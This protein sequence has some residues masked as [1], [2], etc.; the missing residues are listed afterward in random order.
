M[1]DLPWLVGAALAGIGTFA[2][3]AGEPSHAWALL[4]GSLLLAARAMPARA[5]S[6]L[7]LGAAASAGALAL[8]PL[9][10]WAR[11]ALAGMAAQALLLALAGPSRRRVFSLIGH[12]VALAAGAWAVLGADAGAP[13]VAL[14]YAAGLGALLLHAQWS[15]AASGWE[16]VVLALVVLAVSALSLVYA[17]SLDVTAS[18]RALV[19]AAVAA[20]FTCGVAALALAARPPPA[21]AAL[22]QRAGIVLD[23]VAHG[24]AAIALLNILFLAFSLVSGWSLR[25]VFTVLLTWQLLV[26]G[27]EF[28]TVRHAE[29]R[30]RRGVTAFLRDARPEPVTVVVPAANEAEVLPMSL[31]H[32]LRVPYPLQFVLVPAAKSTDGTV[33]LAH[34][35]ARRHPDRV[36][37]VEGTTGSKAE[38][39]N[40]AWR[41]IRTPHVLLLDADE[42]IDEAS[43][44]RALDH[45][46]RD[47]QVG[48]V[49]GRKV[50]RAPKA[51]PLARF[52]SAERRY[53]TW[54]DH[55]MHGESLGSSHF[56]GSAAL[57]RRE[58]PLSLGGWTDR[59]MTEDIE[60]TLRVHLDDRWRIAY[61][62]EM[63][64][65]E[66]DPSTVGELLKQRT[67]WARG[68]AQCFRIYFG[69]IVRASRRLGATRA[70]GLLLLL[71]ISV[72]ALWTTFVPATLLMRIA[73]ISPLLPII[74]AL[75]LALV[76][77][78][79]RLLA[80]SYAA[81]RDPVIP[82]ERTPARFA[83]LALHAYLWILFGWFVQ[84]HALYL[85]VSSAPRVWYVTNKKARAAA[86]GG[87]T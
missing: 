40:L 9:A 33:A 78:P 77:L 15:R 55:V 51:G 7:A 26:I 24:A 66:C 19:P 44:L 29:R 2:I 73:G 14:A 68:W 27:M 67:R 86:A 39:L 72:S 70:F 84:L 28:R 12:G 85:E 64:V 35:Y 71:L 21:P 75:P 34:E 80:Y 82:L 31:E 50:S 25:L 3:L 43:L 11:V 58:V 56:G 20:A 74:V 59:T 17:A 23:V 65:R 83:E 22:R 53:C 60:F 6:A 87:P 13:V 16:V 38:D 52:V 4:A 62:P 37:V 69:D 49:Q 8:L 41:T 5:A 32:N 48:V 57:L 1:R 10:P 46:R 45:M 79:A 30:R 36:R 61:L 54:L 81:F 63:V 76:L 47:P 18:V 42:T